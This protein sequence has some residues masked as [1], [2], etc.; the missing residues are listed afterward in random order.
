MVDDQKGVLYDGKSHEKREQRVMYSWPHTQLL[1][2][3]TITRQRQEREH[4]FESHSHR[5]RKVR[6]AV[7]RGPRDEQKS[8]TG[9]RERERE[10]EREEE[11]SERD[12]RTVRDSSNK[13]G[14]VEGETKGNGVVSSKRKR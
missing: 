7:N 1:H 12:L 14:K 2:S 13:M 3:Y 11:Y 4:K 9:E 5:C 10:R 8:N 6:A